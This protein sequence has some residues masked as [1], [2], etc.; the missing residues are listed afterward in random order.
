[1]KILTDVLLDTELG[2]ATMNNVN[3]LVANNEAR[4]PAITLGAGIGTPFN[5]LF[6]HR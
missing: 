5:L 6:I 3:K 2:R 4:S 1:M